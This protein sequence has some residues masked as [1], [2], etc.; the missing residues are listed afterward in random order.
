MANVLED[1][2]S[3]GAGTLGAATAL[4]NGLQ[5][6]FVR[7][8]KEH[9]A[10]KKLLESALSSDGAD[11]R[12]DLWVKVRR[13]LL[14]HEQAERSV[15]YPT[16]SGI[17]V[18][19]EHARSAQELESLIAEVDARAYDSDAW[20]ECVQRL[21]RA[22][23]AHAEREETHYFPQMQGMFGKQAAKDIEARYEREKQLTMEA[24]GG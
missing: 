20:A 21:L 6:V 18:T 4:A 16:F 14:S 15:L 8:S 2:V 24:L 5:G 19:D 3:K 23:E 9:K 7:L 12:Q 1:I 22:V 17:G 13:E 10:A 11:K